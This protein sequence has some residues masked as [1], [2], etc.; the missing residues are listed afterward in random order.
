M[1]MGT[2]PSRI[3]KYRRAF[4]GGNHT[5]TRDRIRLRRLIIENLEERRVLATVTV[6]TATDNNDSG[7]LVGATYSVPWLTSNKGAD[8]K[9]SLREA[10]IAANNTVGMDTIAFNIAS[11]GPSIGIGGGGATQQTIS[12]GASGLGALPLQSV[13]YRFNRCQAPIVRGGGV[14]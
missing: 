4:S 9:I 2:N 12:V 1:T 14:W 3:R 8:G 6:D 7:I 11:G 5:R 13:P 10:I